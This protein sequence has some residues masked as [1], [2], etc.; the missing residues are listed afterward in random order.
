MPLRSGWPPIDFPV[1]CPTNKH[2]STGAIFIL[3]KVPVRPG[4]SYGSMAA[5]QMAEFFLRGDIRSGRETT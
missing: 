1:S 3:S 2:A 4:A 5:T